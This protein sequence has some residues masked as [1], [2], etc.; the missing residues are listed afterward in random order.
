[1]QYVQDYDETYPA[2]TVWSCPSWA[3]LPP[4]T[5]YYM[6]VMNPYIKSV[7]FWLCPSRDKDD[8]WTGAAGIPAC[9]AYNGALGGGLYYSSGWVL[10]GAPMTLASVKMP[11]ST[12]LAGE[13]IGSS[14]IFLPPS[15]AGSNSG[16]SWAVWPAPAHFRHFDGMNITL[17][18]GHAKWYKSSNPDLANTDDRMWN[19]NGF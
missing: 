9:F 1:M 16:T 18:D 14:C 2:S 3:Y 8:T 15:G 5:P 17:A 7:D 10:P 11:A 6:S 12:V 19:G 13:C 4:G